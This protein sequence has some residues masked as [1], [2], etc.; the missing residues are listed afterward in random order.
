MSNGTVSTKRYIGSICIDSPRDFYA[1]CE[2]LHSMLQRVHVRKRQCKLKHKQL[3]LQFTLRC[4]P[5]NP[6][7]RTHVPKRYELNVFVQIIETYELTLRGQSKQLQ[8]YTPLLITWYSNE[9]TQTTQQLACDGG[10]D[11]CNGTGNIDIDSMFMN[12]YT[13]VSIGLDGDPSISVPIHYRVYVHNETNHSSIT[14]TLTNTT[15]WVVYCS[16]FSTPHGIEFPDGNFG[17]IIQP[18]QQVVVNIIYNRM[19]TCEYCVNLPGTCEWCTKMPVII[20]CRV[21]YSRFNVP[22]MIIPICNLW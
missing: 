15:P 17:I 6:Y 22:D 14:L 16:S 4:R 10:C 13:C 21:R 12:D 19:L 9:P 20:S 7:R 2:E 5:A 8:P 1:Y 18:R 3:I 11:G